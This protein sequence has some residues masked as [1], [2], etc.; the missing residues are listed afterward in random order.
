[1]TVNVPRR[2]VPPNTLS[3]YGWPVSRDGTIP[4]QHLVGVL[5][6]PCDIYADRR[7]QAEAPGAIRALPWY[8]TLITPDNVE[9][10]IDDVPGV[11]L[12]D[13]DAWRMAD[14]GEALGAI[15]GALP[16]LRD[17]QLLIVLGGDDAV[18]LPVVDQ[19]ADHLV[20]LDAHTD[21]WTYPDR[22]LRHG[23]WVDHLAP[24]ITVWQPYARVGPGRSLDTPK[25]GA[26]TVLVFDLDCVDTGAAP[27]VV[28]PV[29]GGRPARVLLDLVYRYCATEHVRAVVV[30]E[31]CPSRDHNDLTAHLAASVVQHAIAGHM[32]K[33]I[34]P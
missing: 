16:D 14:R 11:D 20:H 17:D 25:T 32:S 24:D 19:Y 21:R 33:M 28:A 13:V 29:P 9:F 34:G 3:M 5:G 27:G 4:P 22:Q 6:V 30:T 10:A 12:G 23:S 15:S 2:R 26:R 7:G 31:L 8:D 1:M 18:S